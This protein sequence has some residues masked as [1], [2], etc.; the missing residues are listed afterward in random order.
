MRPSFWSA[1]VLGLACSA[2]A[3]PASAQFIIDHESSGKRLRGLHGPASP[4]IRRSFE[5]DRE[6]ASVFREILAATGI[7]GVADRIQVRAS[8]ETANAEAQIGEDG[9]RYIFYNSTFMRELGARTRQFW[10][11]VFVI[12]HEVGHHIAGHLDFAGQN[13]RVELEADRYAGF[14]LGR[15]GAT[16]DEAIAAI[17]AIGTGAGSSTHPPRDQRVQIVSLGWNDGATA[18]GQQRSIA[19]PPVPPPSPPSV[20][21]TPPPSQPPAAAL[22][23]ARPPPAAAPSAGRGNYAFRVSTRL[24]GNLITTSLQADADGCRRTCD[25]KTGCVGYQYG[26]TPPLTKTCQLFDRVTGRAIDGNWGS[27]LREDL[28][29]TVSVIPL[30]PSGPSAVPS[31]SPPPGPA[32]GPPPQSRGV[33]TPTTTQVGPLTITK[34]TPLTVTRPAPPPPAAA[35]K[36]VEAPLRFGYKT[37][38]NAGVAGELINESRVESPV[39]CLLMCM[40]TSQ[41]TTAGFTEPAAGQ[42]LCKIYREGAR[43]SSDQPGAVTVIFKP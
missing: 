25:Q 27:G 16:H 34:S 5:S 21:A 18:P 6:A 13:H 14:I 41:C 29:R 40:N 4:A 22:P 30:P 39:A 1:L 33:D 43:I 32:A 17:G 19:A 37:R 36:S 7:P 15:M 23:P 2:I 11:Q 42:V 8:A 38:T 24:E 26:G 3:V 35:P 10:S 28:A 12:A 9:Q 20:A 31:Q